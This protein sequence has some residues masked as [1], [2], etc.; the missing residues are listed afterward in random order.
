MLK[1]VRK[2]SPDRARFNITAIM[3]ILDI[4]TDLVQSACQYTGREPAEAVCYVLSDYP[5]LISDLREARRRLLDFDN[6][7]ENLDSI[8]DKLNRISLLI[9]DL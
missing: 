4:P 6:E 5:R 2:I 1:R 7:S 3:A 8:V 9:Q